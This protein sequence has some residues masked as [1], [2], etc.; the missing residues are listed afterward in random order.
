MRCN[1]V[2]DALEGL[3]NLVSAL[4]LLHR[5]VDLSVA[6]Y[7]KSSLLALLLNLLLHRFYDVFLGL[8]IRYKH[9][10]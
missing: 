3:D 4:V 5:V 7:Q 6:N 2:L 1:G 8:L 9:D 10:Q